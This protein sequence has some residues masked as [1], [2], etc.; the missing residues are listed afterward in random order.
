MIQ[1]EKG[2]TQKDFYN[3]SEVTA[4]P[5]PL[6]ETYQFKVIYKEREALG[7]VRCLKCNLIYVNPRLKNPEKVYW[8]DADKYTKEAKLIFEGKAPHY[9]D[10]NYLEDLHLIK[11]Y[12]PGGNFLDV[13][14]NMGFFLRNAK[15]VS[16]KW[17]LYGVDP[18]S[19]LTDIARKYFGLNV[20]T[21]F[22]EDAGF[23]DNFF[24]VITMTDVF[25]HITEPKKILNENRRILKPDGILFIKVPNGQFNLFKYY[26][27]KMMGRLKDYDIFDSYEHVVHYSNRTLK[28]MLNNCGFKLVKMTIGRPIQIPVWHKLVGHYYQYPSPWSLDYKRQAGRTFFYWLSFVEFLLRGQQTGYLAPNIIAVAKKN[29]Y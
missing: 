6:C 16:T 19:T 17:N 29:N 26:M 7:I 2:G 10:P 1:Y 9:R 14:T 12:K 3:E 13:G 24:D 27:A 20:K 15:K 21:A 4:V 22:L 5:C 23:E 25:E 11:R 28:T 8:G 18:S